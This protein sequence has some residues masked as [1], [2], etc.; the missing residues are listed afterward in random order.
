MPKPKVIMFLVTLPAGFDAKR[1]WESKKV[2]MVYER[3]PTKDLVSN[4]Y[5]TF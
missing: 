2:L 4:F 5:E 1:W 3:H